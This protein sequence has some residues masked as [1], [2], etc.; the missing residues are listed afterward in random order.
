M[1]IKKAKRLYSQISV[2]DKKFRSVRAVSRFYEIPDCTIARW[3]REEFEKTNKHNFSIT[4]RGLT[5]KVQI[6]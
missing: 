3:I 5:F 4:K 1:E 6:F 2:G